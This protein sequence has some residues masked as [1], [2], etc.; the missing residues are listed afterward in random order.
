MCTLQTEATYNSVVKDTRLPEGQLF[1]LPVTLD[2]DNEEI[3]VGDFVELVHPETGAQGVLQVS[4]FT[5][6]FRLC[7]RY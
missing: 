2:T 5:R 1:G 3:K 6:C 4:R 7:I